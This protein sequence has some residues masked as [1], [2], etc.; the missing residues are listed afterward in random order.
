MQ[1][2]SLSPKDWLAHVA[3]WRAGQLTRAAYCAQ[4]DLKLTSLIYPKYLS[5]FQSRYEPEETNI[6]LLWLYGL[7]L[8]KVEV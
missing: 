3:R 2:K 1:S 7:I 4:N 6:E 5:I 8:L